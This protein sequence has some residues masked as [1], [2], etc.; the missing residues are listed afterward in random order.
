M[1]EA[2]PAAS[3]AAAPAAAWPALPAAAVARSVAWPAAAASVKHFGSTTESHENHMK[4]RVT[5]H[6][7][8]HFSY[9]LALSLSSCINC[10]SCRKI[11]HI[12]SQ[13][14]TS[15]L[16]E[17]ASKAT[18]LSNSSSSPD[19]AETM[20]WAGHRLMPEPVDTSTNDGL[21]KEIETTEKSNNT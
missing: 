9:N 2:F 1:L 10:S 19:L 21:A 3:P 4:V 5:S 12:D 6:H 15:Q 16:F 13:Q 11:D 20:R 8:F 7:F 17:F 14:K 18:H